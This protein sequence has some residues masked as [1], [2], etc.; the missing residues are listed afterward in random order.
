VC[1]HHLL[2]AGYRKVCSKDAVAINGGAA[3]LG[4]AR[5]TLVITRVAWTRI[6]TAFD[7]RNYCVLCAAGKLQEPGQVLDANDKE[8]RGK[9][10]KDFIIRCAA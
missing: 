3:S 7:I 8:C 2:V 4:V 10:K 9:D 1:A 5:L 6:Q